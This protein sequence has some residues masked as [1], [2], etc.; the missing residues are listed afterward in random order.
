MKYLIGTLYLIF[1]EKL[2]PYIQYIYVRTKSLIEKA[3]YIPNLDN[4]N[5]SK[6]QNKES[7]EILKLLYRF[8]EF[9]ESAAE[10]NEPSIIARYLIDVAQKFSTFYNEHKIITED[11]TIQDARLALT[12]TVGIVL[13]TGVTLLGMEMPNKM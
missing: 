4:I 1:K 12:Y 5:F 8:N 6:L 7:I 13:K 2:G 3:G 10:K 11:K 9:V